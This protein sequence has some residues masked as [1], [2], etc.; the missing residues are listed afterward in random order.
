MLWAQC[1]CAGGEGS[2]RC[3]ESN[4]V[5]QHSTDS[6]ADRLGWSHKHRKL[7]EKCLRG[8]ANLAT[9]KRTV[10]QHCGNL[11][12]I[13]TKCP[14]D[15]SEKVNNNGIPRSVHLPRAWVNYRAFVKRFLCFSCPVLRR[16]CSSL[17]PTASHTT[18]VPEYKSGQL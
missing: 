4:P 15:L 9:T 5:L 8:Q 10:V 13:S 17:Q 16:K 3:Q 6:R 7:A 18:Q 12:S 2:I 14:S 11:A 1:R